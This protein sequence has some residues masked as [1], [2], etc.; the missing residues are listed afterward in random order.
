MSL[1]SSDAYLDIK[2]NYYIYLTCF[3]I[4]QDRLSSCGRIF[5]TV[6]CGWWIY[7]FIVLF[8]LLLC[9]LENFQNKKLFR[10]KV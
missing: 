4:P 10:L 5:I 1:I 8:C 2:E 3:E 7:E 6:A 9:I